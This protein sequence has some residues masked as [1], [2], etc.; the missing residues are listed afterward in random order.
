MAGHHRIRKD[1]R[2][3]YA[4]TVAAWIWSQ[5]TLIAAAITAPLLTRFLSQPEYG[6]WTQL[7]S[8][9][10]FGVAADMGMS[11]VF[12]RRLTNDPDADRA[13][14]VRS[15]AAFYRSSTIVLAAVLLVACWLPD[16]VLSPYLSHTST[17]MLAAV[18][19]IA[20][21]AVNQ[22]SQTSA[23]HLRARGRVDVAQIFGAGPAVTGSIATTLAAYWFG[24]A[25][26]VA[27]T[28]AVV[29]IVFDVGLVIT[30][31]RGRHKTAAAASASRRTLAWWVRLWYESTGILVVDLA[32]TMSVV[33]GVTILGH[34]SGATAVAT[35]GVAARIG[36]FVGGFI[37]PFTDSLFVSLCR[38][39]ANT[40][41]AMTALV[42]R[43]SVVALAVGVTAAFA[44]VAV[45][46]VGL[47]LVFGP[48]YGS[49]VWAALVMILAGTVRSTYRPFLRRIQSENSIGFLRFWFV[50]STAV[51]IPLVVL[52]GG[53]RWSSAGA[54]LA[55]LVCSVVFE[56]MP[57]AWKFG[58]GRRLLQTVNRPV[59][60]ELL[61][62]LGAGCL[63]FMLAL[64]RQRLGSLAA[65]IAAVAAASTGLFVLHQVIRYIA[66]AR[67]IRGSSLAPGPG[68]E[69]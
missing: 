33:I 20:A 60:A 29:E 34:V 15:A 68:E 23:L 22:R 65:S 27:L 44:V 50:A 62:A 66:A 52:L 56:A 30:A 32:P 14:T 46:P 1:R 67:L 13:S 59:I 28:Y 3:L 12:L 10:A 6:L 18:A 49:A 25:T 2:E 63:A 48:G 21:I 57:A 24:T 19:V 45:G 11:L 64:G 53:T 51:Q 17:P 35:Y 31:N 4:N 39:T 58:A 55:V 42:I 36:S 47:R 7:L 41:G 43:L 54:A 9:S 38:A 8:L 26:A 16:G 40:R 69:K 5:G 61:A 37:M